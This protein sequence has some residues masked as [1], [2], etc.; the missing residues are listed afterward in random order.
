MPM[1]PAARPSVTF[2]PLMILVDQHALRP[3]DDLPVPV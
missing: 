1:L 2:I 3:L